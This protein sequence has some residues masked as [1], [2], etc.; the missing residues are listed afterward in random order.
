MKGVKDQLLCRIR[1][2]ETFRSANL[3]KPGFHSP[4]PA[5]EPVLVA[6]DNLLDV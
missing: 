5:V 1:I 2:L 6:A 4:E 3:L